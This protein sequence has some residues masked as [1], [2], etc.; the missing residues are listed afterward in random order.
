MINK[1]TKGFNIS[2]SIYIVFCIYIV[3]MLL[4][5]TSISI[6]DE[7]FE[8]IIRIIRFVC[9]FFF[10]AKAF[11][12]WKNGKN[13]ITLTMFLIGIL[14][15]IIYYFSGK[16]NLLIMFIALISLKNTDKNKIIKAALITYIITYSLVIFASIIGLIPDWTYTRG[17]TIRHSFG[18]SYPTITMVYYLMIIL[19]Y[20]YTR[21]SKITI[22]EII[23][24]EIINVLLYNSTAG[25]T[26]YILVTIVLIL[27]VLKKAKFLDFLLKKDVFQKMLKGCC[28][29]IPTLAITFILAMSYLYNINDS[30][31]ISM[32][33]MLSNRLQL[34]CTAFQ[35]Y[36][37]TLFGQDTQWNGWGGFG[38]SENIDTQNYVYNYLD[39]SYARLIL[40]YGVI[41]TILVIMG[42]TIILIQ[43]YKKKDYWMIFIIFIILVL[44]ELEPHLID[45]NKN[46]FVI[47]FIPLLEYK[48][49][50]KLAYSNITKNLHI[51]KGKEK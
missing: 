18:F 10:I 45:F 17:E 33:K 19:M 16:K 8:N 4:S 32:N 30:F 40:D 23:I 26:T 7:I 51:K 29:I 43:N 39:N 28:Y 2:N 50:E 13:K 1:K 6:L 47:C 48:P 34:T 25:R 9:Y 46:I 5:E 42:Y 3:T 44:S 20:I 27:L 36:D 12:N 38:Y 11:W 31:A 24:M 22:Y 41:F 49:I 21:K 35:D 14:F 37:V 15:L